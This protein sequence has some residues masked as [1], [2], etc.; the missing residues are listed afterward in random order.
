MDELTLKIGLFHHEFN[1]EVDVL[2]S[3]KL[4][5]FTKKFDES[6][7]S[8][9]WSGFKAHSGPDLVRIGTKSGPDLVLFW[10]ILVLFDKW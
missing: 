3:W 4:R 6:L 9:Y 5:E 2:Q 8:W 1:D 7:I 10:P